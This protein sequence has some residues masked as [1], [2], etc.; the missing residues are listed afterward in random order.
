MLLAF[1]LLVHV[2][3]YTIIFGISGAVASIFESKKGR[4]FGHC[5]RIWGKLIIFFSFIPIRI[6][7]LDNLNRADN[8][9]FCANH[10]S[11][12]DVPIL[13]HSLPYWLVPIAKIEVKRIPI[14][15]LVM[16]AGGHIFVDRSNHERAISSMRKAKDELLKGEKSIMLFPEGSRSKGGD[17]KPFKRAGLV[18]AIE[19]GIS[20]VPIAIINSH[21][22]HKKGTLTVTRSNI[23]VKIGEPIV[24]NKLKPDNKK[25]FPHYVRNKVIELYDS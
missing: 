6:D 1:W 14:L 17:I 16:N 3:I 13:F 11:M 22:L 23:H 21:K 24:V 10:G 8:Y 18:I 2:V 20:V 12:F 4:I 15:G 19:S 9:I 5:A 25:Q 7:G